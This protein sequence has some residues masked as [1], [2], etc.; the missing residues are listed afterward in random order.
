VRAS[1]LFAITIAI[2]IG[3]AVAITAK[4]TGFFNRTEAP[5]EAKKPDIQILAAAKPLFEGMPVTSSDVVVRALRP[6]ELEHYRLHKDRYLPPV[7]GA[8]ALRL[9]QRNVEAD[10][11]ILKEYLGDLNS[12]DALNQRLVQNMRA[13]N[14]AVAKDDSAGGLIRVGEWV[15]VY[16]T[17]SIELGENK[18]ETT[19]TASIARS[20][21]VIAKRNTLWPTA[22][23]LPDDKPVHYTLEANPYRVALIE[24]AKERGKLSLVALSSAEQRTLEQRRNRALQ[25]GEK[26]EP[27]SFAAAGSKE[28]SQEDLRVALF[29]KGELTVEEADLIRIFAIKP[30]APAPAPIKVEQY[31]GLTREQ[32][33]VFVPVP[34]SGDGK[35]WSADAQDDVSAQ[36]GKAAGARKGGLGITFARPETKKCKCK[37][38]KIK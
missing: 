34:Q 25:L 4:V 1:T 33:A 15:D 30:A 26:M 21:R 17:S 5:A 27:S 2:L 16:L 6:E 35:E 8:A 28:Y 3:L 29:L 36:G 18:G 9:V 14:V 37:S 19:R 22:T 20:V 11:P 13:V 12:P 7:V 24:F 10:R 32:S 38:K 23:P 31:N